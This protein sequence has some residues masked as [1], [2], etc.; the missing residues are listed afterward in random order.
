MGLKCSIGGLPQF[1]HRIDIVKLLFTF[2]LSQGRQI[3][4]RLFIVVLLILA[5]IGNSQDSSLKK[6]GTMWQNYG[7]ASPEGMFI[8]AAY[9]QGAIEGLRVGAL[10]GYFQGKLDETKDFS[11]YLKQC[12]D[13][14]RACPEIP[15]SLAKTETIWNEAS[16]G[17]DKVR[18]KFTPQHASVL[19][20]VHQM[21][22]FYGDYRNTPV[23][24]I[25]ALQESIDSL[26]G[27]ASTE[28]QLEMMRKSSCNP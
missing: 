5:P 10:V 20:I 17:A 27:T 19:D 13:K 23:C 2:Q 3:M 7:N 18:A 28:Q 21:D 22:K 4:R 26:N 24:M 16:S 12:A 25:H 15:V 9:V 14:G 1:G 11:D 6:D 8:K